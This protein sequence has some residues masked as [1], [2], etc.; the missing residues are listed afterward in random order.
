[1][2]FS[3]TIIVGTL[4]LGC[5]INVT[6]GSDKCYS[7]KTCIHDGME[8]CGKNGQGKV[9]RFIDSCDIKEYNCLKNKDYEK[10]SIQDCKSLPPLHEPAEPL[11]QNETED[12][13]ATNKESEENAP[14]NKQSEENVGTSKEAI[15]KS[16]EEVTKVQEAVSKS[17][18]KP[19]KIKGAISNNGGGI[20]F[21]S[22][23][24]ER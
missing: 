2:D 21:E 5:V 17:K 16:K 8:K 24:D 23:S 22:A 13:A 12:N 15:S 20:S 7:A 10:T 11:V 19:I 3:A 1:M 14:S 4:L 18:E 9:R 6:Y